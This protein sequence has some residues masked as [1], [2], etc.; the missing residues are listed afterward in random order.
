VFQICSGFSDSA[1]L[2]VPTLLDF[3]STV[4]RSMAPKLCSSSNTLMPT[5]M[6]PG[7]VST[8]LSGRYWPEASRRP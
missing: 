4:A 1:T 5:L 3:A 7:E 2:A 6:K 8:T